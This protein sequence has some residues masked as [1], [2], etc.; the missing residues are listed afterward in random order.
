MANIVSVSWGDHLI[1]GEGEGRLDT[2][3]AVYHRMQCWREELNATT[4]H[5]RVPRHDLDG[6]FYSAKDYP[7]TQVESGQVEWDYA[8]II[9]TIAHRLGMRAYLYVSIFDEGWP[10]PP[11]RVREKSYHNA[12]HG[13]HITWQSNFNRQN[14]EYTVVDRIGENRQWGVMSLS[15]LVVRSFFRERF[16]QMMANTSFDGLF[17]CLRSQSRPPDFADRFGFNEPIRQEFLKRYDRDIL[18][19]DFDLQA[20]RDLQGEYLTQFL[21]MAKTDLK[22]RGLRLGVGAPRGDIV[23][24]PLGNVTLPWRDWIASG[25]VNDLVVNQNSSRCPSMGHDLWPMH[26]GYGYV[27]NYLDGH[28]LPALEEHL[29]NTYAPVFSGQNTA[30]LYVA[31]QWDARNEE[32]EGLLSGLP[33]VSGLVFSSFQHDHPGATERDWVD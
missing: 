24:P 31:R 14:P 8:Q 25:V 20:W 33:G 17:V 1:F 21:R 13:Q 10:L 7:Q 2:P 16:S 9:P 27:Q 23:G 30:C 15:Y 12:M 26:R 29:E 3:V 19:E 6:K 5:W 4:I 22:K 32:E 28:N 11:K 18:T